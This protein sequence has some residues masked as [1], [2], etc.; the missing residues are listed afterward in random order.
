MSK[1]SKKKRSHTKPKG[2]SRRRKNATRSRTDAK[3]QPRWRRP[4]KDDKKTA[5]KKARK[6][7]KVKK[8]KKTKRR[9]LAKR[10]TLTAALFNLFDKVGVKKVTYSK[11]L[12]AAQT[13]KPDTAFNTAHFNKYKQRYLERKRG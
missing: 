12:K 4:E 9:G 5:G 8:T 11:A 13:A 3:A 6:T 10:G 2:G 7:R 1:G